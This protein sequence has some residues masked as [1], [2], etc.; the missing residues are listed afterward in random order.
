MLLSIRK[1]ECVDDQAKQVFKDMYIFVN[2]V[3]SYANMA[4]YNYL[5][6][7]IDLFSTSENNTA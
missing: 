6:I 2:D 4:F 7:G 3:K 5:S 1:N